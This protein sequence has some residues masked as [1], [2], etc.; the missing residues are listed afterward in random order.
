M[1]NSDSEGNDLGIFTNNQKPT[2]T[3]YS[4]EEL[5][6]NEYLNCN[7][8]LINK[9][10]EVKIDF[11]NKQELF[12]EKNSYQEI[13]DNNY[14]ISIELKNNLPEQEYYCT[15]NFRDLAGN[16]DNFSIDNFTVDITK[17]NLEYVSDSESNLVKNNGIQ[18]KTD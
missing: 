3:I 8:E 16:T 7:Q 18:I 15:L 12:K 5:I 13:K 14:E 9:L 17:P 11:E 6:F 4:N 10:N 1:V 2:F